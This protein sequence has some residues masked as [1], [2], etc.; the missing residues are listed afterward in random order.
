MSQNVQDAGTDLAQSELLK[1]MT[2]FVQGV[3]KISKIMESIEVLYKNLPYLL[4]PLLV[5]T[6]L[7]IKDYSVKYLEFGV[8]INFIP[9]IDLL[10]IYNS[11][12]AFGMFDL[13][14]RIFSNI[15]FVIGLFI[16]IYLF[17]LMKDEN[18]LLRKYSF[19]LI[20]GGA[21]GNLID[22]IPDGQVTDMFHF[23]TS[24]FSFFVFN[25]ADAFISVGAVLII[26]SELFYKNEITK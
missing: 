17:K 25:P 1:I 11:G 7:L 8:S 13:D 21:L 15:I 18:T 20:V 2:K 10:L 4:I 6:D 14:E 26:Y 3:L 22:R 16:V 9:L 19:A 5:L 23:H 12:I 24:N